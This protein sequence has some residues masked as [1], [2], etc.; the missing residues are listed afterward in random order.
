MKIQMLIV[1]AFIFLTSTLS[2]ATRE[3]EETSKLESSAIQG[4]PKIQTDLAVNYL[5][6]KRNEAK[7]AY[8]LTQAANENYGPAEYLLGMILVSDSNDVPRVRTGGSYL[9][10]S[11]SHGC[12]GAAGQLG[13]IFLATSQKY[14][15]VESKAVAYIKQAAQG[16][17][18]L[19]QL[20]LVRFYAS[21]NNS[22]QQDLSMSYAWLEFARTQQPGH[23]LAGFAK[24]LDDELK[25]KLTDDDRRKSITLLES[26]RKTY[27]KTKHEFC[28]QSVPDEM[29]S[30]IDIKGI[31]RFF[32]KPY[33]NK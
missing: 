23:R 18:Y 8:W 2:W 28:S 31:L 3:S 30:L 25:L 7:A 27:G 5:I 29:L 11:A 19:S 15:E 14:P 4:D 33:S 6:Q 9:A 17:D 24:P 12:A 32:E 1:M 21:G 10:R 13:N 26:L 22:I 20:M 16:G